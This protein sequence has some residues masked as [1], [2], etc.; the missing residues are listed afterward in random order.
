[1]KKILSAVIIACVLAPQLAFG[2]AWTLPKGD[3]WAQWQTKWQWSKEQYLWNHNRNKH[4]RDA[5]SRGW[6]FIPE[7]HYGATDWLDF[8]YKMEYKEGQYKE[9]ARP[10]AWGPYSVK[11]HGLV[12]FEPAVKVR[13]LK[14]PMVISTQFWWLIWNDDYEALPLQDVAEQP[15]LSDRTN[16]F[17]MR[18]LLGKKWDTQMPFYMG[19]ETG[20]RFNQRNICNQIPVFYEAGVWPLKWLLIKTEIDALISHDGVPTNTN[21]LEKS[22]AIWR[23]GPSIQLLTLYQM[24][25]GIDVKSKDYTSDVTRVSKS[26][27][28]ETQYGNTFWGKN[29]SA[30]HEV[31]L[32]VSAQ[33]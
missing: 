11:N 15:G 27:N 7:V 24:F 13:L 14:E 30:G 29:T 12:S 17:D 18:I 20:Y 10:T 2:G 5:R 33:F 9:Y 22:Y 4:T 26:F 23:I 1:M 25:K 16:A 8:M 19:F 3:V 21:R 32:K 31:V 28:V 6:G